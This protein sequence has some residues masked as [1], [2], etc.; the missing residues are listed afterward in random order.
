M[1]DFKGPSSSPQSLFG[2]PR[3]R[4]PLPN[5][6]IGLALFIIT[7]LASF[8][9]VETM[10]LQGFVLALG[11]LLGIIILGFVSMKEMSLTLIAWM[12]V[13]SGFRYIGMVRMPVL[14]DISIDR[15]LL[16]W[17]ITM[18]ILRTVILGGR[19]KGPY[20]ADLL[21]LGHTVYILVQMQFIGSQDHFHNWVLSMLTP[22]FAFLYGKYTIKK[23]TE[24]RNL[25]LFFLCLSVYYFI[26]SIGQHFDIRQLVWPKSILDPNA[27]LWH[28]GRS[29]GPVLHPPYFGQ[30]IVIIQLV[31][32]FFLT[33]TRNFG[34]KFVVLLGLGLS[35]LGSFYT[36]TR[37]PWAA[38]LVGFMFLAVLSSQFRKVIL[39]LGLI[40][41]LGGLLGMT[42]LADTEFFQERMANTGT[43]ENRLGFLANTFRVIR[44]HPFFGIGYFQ[45]MENLGDYNKSTYI[46]FY[47]L[48]KKG[49]SS[50]VPIHDIYLGRL[51]EEGIVGS[52]FQLA[53]YVV[54]LRA[55]LVK[56]KRNVW[57]DWFNRETMVML[58][59]MMTVYLVGGMVI[60]YRYF[61]LI[62]VIF[63]LFAGLV[64]GY[65]PALAGQK[66]APAGQGMRTG[67]V[68]GIRE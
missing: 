30:L 5:T 9:I 60:D 58:G 39:V 20:L 45:W 6:L 18:F 21:F 31:Y 57:S 22:F 51:A 19:L 66:S 1:S 67:V 17:I 12:L 38:A 62:N 29:R 35:M 46:P 36:F 41:F 59:A 26:C 8:V 13:M 52:F 44:D 37:G 49:M 65:D 68:G 33:R 55:F 42:Q 7:L 63:Y 40:A 16:V 23:D 2:N 4:R 27:G 32:F 10:G 61:D 11:G 25:L 3:Q 56:W 48:V 14:P 64:Y 47:G 15:I 54:I 24:L 28:R 34:M 50:H 43:V 53:F